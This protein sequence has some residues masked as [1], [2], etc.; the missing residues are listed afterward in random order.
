MKSQP[1]KWNG[2]KGWIIL[3]SVIL[4]LAASFFA[5]V[6]VY[7]RADEAAL[8]FMNSDESVAVTATR[9]G[10]LFDGPSED[11]AL[12]FY[13]GGK[14][15]EKAYAPLLHALAAQGLDACLVKMPFRL[16]VLHGNAAEDVLK[17]HGYT[18]WYIGGH[19][20]GGAMAAMYA[21]DHGSDFSGVILLAAYP[22]QKLPDTLTEIQ[23]IGSE[24]RIINRDKVKQGQ[25]YA[26]PNCVEYTIEGGNHAQFGSYGVQRGDGTAAISAE[27]Q[28]QE[29]VRVIMENLRAD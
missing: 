11:A 7:Y 14:V 6:S 23:L 28:I 13:P 20:L 3:A 17:A 8:G 12:I 5:Y 16:A 2:K 9:Y 1:K 15:E 4:L 27:E 22:S 10:W 18:E 24:D 29:T 21:A 26:P 25:A 19:S